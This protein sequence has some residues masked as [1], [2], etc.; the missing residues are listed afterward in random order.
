MGMDRDLAGEAH[1]HAILAL[2][3]QTVEIGDVGVHG[4][5]PVDA[6]R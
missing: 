1:G 5:E 3:P 2:P 4:V 6:R